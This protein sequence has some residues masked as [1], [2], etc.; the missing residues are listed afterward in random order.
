[1]ADS[2][3]PCKM[4]WADPCY[5]GNEILARRRDPVAYRLVDVV[6][7][8][9]SKT[10]TGPFG[11][12]LTARLKSLPSKMRDSSP[13]RT[14]PHL[15]AIDRAVLMLSPVTMR[16]VIPARLHFTIASGTCQQPVQLQIKSDHK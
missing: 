2:M 14:M 9:E 15:P 11:E 13:G 1:M 16:T 12:S 7:R 8:A 10:L 6:S 4:L 5:H 3:E